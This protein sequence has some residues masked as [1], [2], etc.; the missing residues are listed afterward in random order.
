MALTKRAM[1]SLCVV[2][3]DELSPSR[4]S[5]GVKPDHWMRQVAMVAG[6]ITVYPTNWVLIS[7][8]IKERM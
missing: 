5:P 3:A 1:R 6:F 7:M 8:G 4:F 2:E